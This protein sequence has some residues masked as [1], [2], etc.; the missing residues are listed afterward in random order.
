ME[1]TYRTLAE[2]QLCL[3]YSRLLLFR[4]CH[5]KPLEMTLGKHQFD[6]FVL[7]FVQISLEHI[8]VPCPFWRKQGELWNCCLRLFVHSSVHSFVRKNCVDA[9]T[10]KPLVRFTPNQVHWNHLGLYRCVASCSFACRDL[11]T[12]F[13]G[14][15]NLH[16]SACF[17]I[18]V[19]TKYSASL[20]DALNLVQM[21]IMNKTKPQIFSGTTHPF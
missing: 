11:G 4:I 2:L 8:I 10:Q 7:I 6:M 1:K 17:I 3:R 13:T 18:A 5:C 16:W 15:G 9:V 14:Q 20:N 21:P 12:V 19:W